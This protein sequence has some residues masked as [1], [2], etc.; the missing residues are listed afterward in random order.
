M[1][2]QNVI[3][4]IETDDWNANKLL[5]TDCFMLLGTHKESTNNPDC[6]EETKMVYSIG[7]VKLGAC[8]L[9][10]NKGEY[11]SVE[12]SVENE[13]GRIEVTKKC[14]ICNSSNVLR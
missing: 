2:Y 7:Q 14:R 5:K 12:Y 11:N 6:T 3:K 8:S 1:E 4:V 10:Q 13:N 9:C